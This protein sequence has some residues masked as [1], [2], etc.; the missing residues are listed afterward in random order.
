MEKKVIYRF[1]AILLASMALAA[2]SA[3]SPDRDM[4]SEATDT[5]TSTMQSAATITGR[6]PNA[7]A[8]LEFAQMR[9]AD[10]HTVAEGMVSPNPKAPSFLAIANT[11]GLTYETL[12]VWLRDSHNYPDMMD[13][14][15][16]A[17][18]IDDLAAHMLTLRSADYKPLPQ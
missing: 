15:I 4:A 8:G 10:C 13:F 14:E 7:A 12:S 17:S 18:H 6:E 2:C 16:E 9:C 11:K 1:T 5:K 3:T